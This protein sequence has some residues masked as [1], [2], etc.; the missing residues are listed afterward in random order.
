MRKEG[1][2]MRNVKKVLAVFVLIIL[3]LG[4]II[5]AKSGFNYGIEYKKVTELKFMLGQVINM[6]DVESIVK[7]AFND[8]E[9]RI[10]KI[11]YFDDSVNIISKSIT[12]VNIS[13]VDPT[14]EEIQTLIDKLNEKYSQNNSMDSISKVKT[15]DISLSK[16]IN[17]YLLPAIVALAIIVL[18]M[19]VRFRKQGVAKVILKP[20]FSVVIVEA[21]F[22]AICAIVRIPITIWTMPFA[23]VLMVITLT[24]NAYKFEENV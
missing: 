19:V 18:Y 10:Q 17:P 21:V 7:E 4:G 3:V 16:I 14:D 9:V 11:D 1:I 24:W 15:A 20:I 8:K 13:V 5:V 6:S 22:F 23:L 12:D 2:K